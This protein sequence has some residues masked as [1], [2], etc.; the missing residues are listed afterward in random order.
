[1][2]RHP[3]NM[4]PLD[5]FNYHSFS[6][7]LPIIFGILN[8][9]AN[10]FKNIFSVDDQILFAIFGALVGIT[11]SSIGTFHLNLPTDLFHFEEEN[12][13]YPLI[14]AP[15]IYSIIFG[16]PIYYLNRALLP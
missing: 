14:I 8:I 9:L 11:F 10:Y 3:N 16:F 2:N 6:I 12:W 4:N 1:M 7:F 13:Y 5:Q 15:I